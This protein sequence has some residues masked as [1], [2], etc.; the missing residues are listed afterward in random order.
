MEIAGNSLSRVLGKAA[1]GKVSHWGHAATE[2][3]EGGYW[4]TLQAAECS[5]AP[6]LQ[7]L[8]LEQQRMPRELDPGEATLASELAEPG[9]Q[10]L[11]LQ[12]LSSALY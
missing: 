1:Q 11:L 4:G 7:G 6:A 8:A 3:P 2:L 9:I 10:N 5:R 12:C